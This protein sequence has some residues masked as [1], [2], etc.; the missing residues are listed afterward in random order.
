[1]E[2]LG[3]IGGVLMG[4]TLGL[5]GAGGSILTVPIL[6]YLFGV[7]PSVAT[8]YSLLIV[9][10]SAAIGS[11][12]Y[13]KND[14]TNFKTGVFFW[15]PSF[16]SVLA[17]RRYLVPNL[18]EQIPLAAGFFIP[19]EALIMGT[20]AI[21]MLLASFSMIRPTA[22]PGGNRH[23]GARAARI[24]LYG[25]GIGAV[26]GFVGAGGGFLIV[27]ALALLLGFP[28]K[29]AVGTSLLIITLNALFGFVSGLR[30]LPQV[31]WA[32]LAGFS[33]FSIV[34]IV[35]GNQLSRRIPGQK[36]KPLFGWFVLIMGSSI[37][38]GQIL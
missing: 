35:L 29:Q 1:M 28:M 38:L 10:I 31:D 16:F 37:L 15:L 34:G 8:A 24:I 27:P 21:I 25:L 3:Y 33:A 11:I 7:T 9:G 4:V 5:I 2:L 19:K 36:L 17:T 32:F 22:R 14:E 26:T 13:L 20:F 12:A 23:A 6:V 30:T 18:P